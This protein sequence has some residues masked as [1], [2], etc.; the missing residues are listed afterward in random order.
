MLEL[1]TN[2]ELDTD[3][4]TQH[5]VYNGLDCC[6]TTETFTKQVL[7]PYAQPIYAWAQQQSVMALS[8]ML[9]GLPVD[10]GERDKLIFQFRARM[11]RVENI[12][13]RMVDALG[14]PSLN[15]RSPKQIAEFFY[16]H[17]NI[18]PI[19]ETYR[20]ITKVKTDRAALEKLLKHPLG[21]YTAKSILECR[22]IHGQIKVLSTGLDLDGRMRFTF[23]PVGTET[24]RWAS[25]GSP[26][27]GGT[28]GQNIT[29][30]MRRIFVPP[31][32]FFLAQFDLAQ[33][34]S[35][36]VAYYSDDEDYIAACESGDLHSQVCQMVWPGKEPKSQWYR[37]LSHRDACKR[38]GHGSNY[39][40][41]PYG[42]AE[43]VGGGV[44]EGLIA[45]FQRD[46]F[47]RFKGIKRWHLRVAQELAKNGYLET[48]FGFRRQ[49][50]SRLWDDKTRKE[51]IAFLPQST[52]AYYMNKG[53]WK[54][55]NTFDR[56]AADADVQLVA[57]GHDSGLMFIREG[58]ED[59]LP[60]ITALLDLPV[61]FPSG[62]I[63]RIPTDCAV[64][65]NWG[66]VIKDKTGKVLENPNGLDES[67][68]GKSLILGNPL[69]AVL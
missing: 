36:G 18:P 66:K 54:I 17:M 48:V 69:D 62:K 8:M 4:N 33:A 11:A 59:L 39:D 27:W 24:G 31:P 30:E 38:F 22:D 50:F 51:A 32:G 49:F 34:E 45:G 44:S 10:I 1:Q 28:Q 15:P 9:R 26:I 47:A 68:S 7:P 14:F 55:F 46:Y 6:V 20:G 2:A 56:G 65:Y 60:E 43:A 12:I 58:R 3:Y 41:T 21:G 19:T 61:T 52:I 13:N 40:G 5:W 67:L 35:R 53:L 64:G 63:M 29:D 57:Q 23:N 25:R 16:S 37:H 42:I